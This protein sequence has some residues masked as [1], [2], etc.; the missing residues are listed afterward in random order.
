MCIF[1]SSMIGCTGSSVPR[2][3]V[4]RKW[5]SISIRMNRTGCRS[6]E[7]NTGLTTLVSGQGTIMK[8]PGPCAVANIGCLFVKYRQRITLRRYRSG[9]M[10]IRRCSG[11]DS[12]GWTTL[13]GKVPNDKRCANRFNVSDFA[14]FSKLLTLTY[15]CGIFM[16]SLY[17]NRRKLD[18]K[19]YPR[20]Q[21]LAKIR[22]FYHAPDLI[23]VIT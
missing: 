2:W 4:R 8:S 9:F 14:I 20:E 12:S 6:Q 17:C 11:R 15:C 1:T 7:R 10:R 19:L 18:M 21:Y 16:V 13:I 5:C 3:T 22:K 23:K